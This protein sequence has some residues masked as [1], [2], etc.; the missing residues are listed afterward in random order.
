MYNK[1]TFNIKY[2]QN[3]VNKIITIKY[4]NTAQST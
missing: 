4:N 2:T 3:K 1:N